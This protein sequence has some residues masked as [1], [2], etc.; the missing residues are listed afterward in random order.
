MSSSF[1][2]QCG[3]Q[4]LPGVNFCAACGERIS[5]PAARVR[6]R[7]VRPRNPRMIA[8]VCSG[9]AIYYGWDIPLVRILYAVFVCVTSGVGLL[10]YPVAW[11]LMPEDEAPYALP[12]NVQTS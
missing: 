1:C 7:M 8:G 10:A 12:A 9:V 11:V 4:Y 5:A 2:P 6:S 3:Q